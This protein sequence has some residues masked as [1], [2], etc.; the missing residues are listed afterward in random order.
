MSD[1]LAS[2]K[3]FFAMQYQ[4]SQNALQQILNERHELRTNKI[5]L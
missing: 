3:S 1:E 4:E 5:V 2:A